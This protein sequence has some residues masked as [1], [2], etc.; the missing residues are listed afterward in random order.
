MRRGFAPWSHS[1]A[2]IAQVELSDETRREDILGI[3]FWP[4]LKY[5]LRRDPP[6]HTALKYV[7]QT[8]L[9]V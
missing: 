8:G 9:R 1:G 3:P 6:T 2:C 7:L 4:K 5:N